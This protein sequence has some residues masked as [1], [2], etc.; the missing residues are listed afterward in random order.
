MKYYSGNI[1][2]SKD[3]I[4]V[5]G[6]NPEGR[7]GAGS[8]KV[9]LQQFGAIYGQGEGLQGSSYALPTTDLRTYSLM[10]KEQIIR[11]IKKMFKVAESMPDKLFKIA[12]R[13]QPNERTLCG[14]TGKEL[15][16]MF[17]SA[18]PYPDN[19]VFS[20]EWFDNGIYEKI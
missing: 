19:V 1:Y 2:P 4:F 17:K 5:F 15:M 10:S 20:K 13:N 9:A 18:A 16:N 6:S 8:A 12:Y 3:T 7:H 14:Y 11:S